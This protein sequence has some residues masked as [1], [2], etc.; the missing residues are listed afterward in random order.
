MADRTHD[1]GLVGLFVDGMAHGFPVNGQTLIDLAVLGVPG[2]ERSIE[3]LGGD[4]NQRVAD[5]RDTRYLVNPITFSTTESTARLL[6]QRL[7]PNR[8]I[9]V[10]AHATQH[11]RGGQGQHTG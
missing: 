10:A 6:P 8:N 1:M 9:L 7:D 2:I 11:R 5:D 4:A 3:L